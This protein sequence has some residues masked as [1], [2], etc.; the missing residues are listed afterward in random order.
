MVKQG[1]KKILVF[2]IGVIGGNVVDFLSR[3]N[4]QYQII[5]ASRNT[6]KMRKRVNLSI[7]VAMSLGFKPQIDFRRVDV[8]DKTQVM[9]LLNDF[10]P[11]LVINATSLQS[12]W[13]ISLL[14]KP[15]YQELLQANIGPWLPNHLST[16]KAV[17]EA[18]IDC[19]TSPLVV[20]ASFPDAVNCAL[21]TQG[22]APTIG[23]GNI[24]NLVPTLERIISKE[25]DVPQSRLQI[26]FA[27]HHVACNSISS[28][29]S[30]GDAPY[31]LKILVDGCEVDSKL[32]H[33]KVF[34][35]VVN[36]YRR[37]RG[38]DGQAVASSSVARVASALLDEENRH[39]LHAPGPQGLVGGYP[40]RIGNGSVSLDCGT[41]SNEKEAKRVNLEGSA[42]EGIKEIK[43]DGT[44][45]FTDREMSVLQYHFGYY[46]KSMHVNDVHSVATELRAK[47]N[48]FKRRYSK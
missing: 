31:M 15:I 38:I 17:M 7:T 3:M 33:H 34:T 2:G 25:L 28:I 41:A 21:H 32:N 45:I 14:P 18:S 12:F 46:C 37:V 22:C 44:I 40:V 13:E 30:P 27:A 26:R 1:R 16:A 42:V 47:Y 4:D 10:L 24:A 11:D 48:E 39:R 43:P 5:V 23:G 9:K 36:D 35:G 8:F 6:E 19:D 29:G 20:N